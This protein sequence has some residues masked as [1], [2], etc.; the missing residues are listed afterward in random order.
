MGRA[1]SAGRPPFNHWLG[2]RVSLKAPPGPASHV[3]A[4]YSDGQR[5]NCALGSVGWDLSA[6][7]TSSPRAANVELRLAAILQPP[8]G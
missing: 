2:A 4:A 5:L 7:A 6:L 8:P 3:H 1:T